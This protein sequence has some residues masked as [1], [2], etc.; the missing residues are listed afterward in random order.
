MWWPSKSTAFYVLLTGAAVSAF[1]LP[2]RWSAWARRFFQ[3]LALAQAPFAWAA[4]GVS[5]VADAGGGASPA[6]V[7]ASALVEENEALQRQVAKQ[8]LRL[9]QAEARVAEL[10][11]LNLGVLESRTR[12]VIA[13]VVGLDSDRRRATLLVTLSE[14]QRRLVRRDQWVVASAVPVPEWDPNASVQD[15]I[16]RE[17]IIGRISE[18]QLLVARVQLTTD[19]AFRAE[20]R[21]ARVRSDGSWEF[22]GS[23]SVLV[24]A[25]E[26]TMLISQATEDYFRSGFRI[27]VVPAGREL[28]APMTLGRITGAQARNDSP[29]HVDLR[30]APWGVVAKLSHVYVLG[31]EP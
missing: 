1:C 21:A 11:R 26:G 27:V 15:L 29:Q 12:V 20:V 2:A 30:V 28:A 9:Q 3:P 25:G 10:T 13:P 5:N 6:L 16:D 19:P 18:V 22:A 24:G 8:R 4:R 14:R 7:E 23:G 17:W 31:T